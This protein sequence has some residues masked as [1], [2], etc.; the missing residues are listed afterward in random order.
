MTALPY[1]N[2]AT[3]APGV[4][5][6]YPAASWS[7]PT[8]NG[9]QPV[10]PVAANDQNAGALLAMNPPGTPMASAEGTDPCAQTRSETRPVRRFFHNLLC[11]DSPRL[12]PMPMPMPTPGDQTA[13]LQQPM[14]PGYHLRTD[15]PSPMPTGDIVAAE[16][17]TQ[18]GPMP[19][20]PEIIQAGPAL[21]PPPGSPPRSGEILQTT[22]AEVVTSAPRAE[23]ITPQPALAATA[24]KTLESIDA[25]PGPPV[26][27]VCERSIRL[28]CKLRDVGP[29]GLS[30]VEV[31]YTQDGKRW[32]KAEH[33]CPPQPPYVMDV[34]DDGRYG[35]TLIAR[36]GLGVAK[37]A[38]VLGEAPQVWVEVD[39]TKPTV[40]FGKAAFVGNESARELAVSWTASD[41][42]LGPKPIKLSY[43]EKA[44]GPWTT[45]ADVENT[46]S[47]RC[48]LPPKAPASFFVRV[49]ATDSAGNT[50]AV[51]S[52]EAVVLDL[53][54]PTVEIVSVESYRRQK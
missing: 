44:Q 54:R 50:T 7:S 27:H 51:V 24:P 10:R 20:S 18:P 46:G 38:P 8:W 22:F 12:S 33:S 28:N 35:I 26:H 1:P 2:V 14:R 6:N 40:Q 21:V 11:G 45:I 15:A 31:W 39:T 13:L 30:A 37:A 16:A 29:S 36:N 23:S 17:R 9:A 42:N 53:S 32:L 34:K 19:M 48:Q 5:Q 25:P 3:S 41:K 43:A 4:A 52:S 47:H 49:Q